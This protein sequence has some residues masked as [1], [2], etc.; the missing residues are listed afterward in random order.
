MIAV[1]AHSLARAVALWL[2]AVAVM[3]AAAVLG[4]LVPTHVFTMRITPEPYCTTSGCV[5]P[6]GSVIR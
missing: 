1:L 5:Q 2:L 4:V 6:D 3:L